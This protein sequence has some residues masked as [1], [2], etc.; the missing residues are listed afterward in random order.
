MTWCFIQKLLS[1]FCA[2]LASS[3][4][5]AAS[6]AGK[7]EQAERYYQQALVSL[8]QGNKVQAVAQLKAALTF[9][10]KLAK[11]H[12]QLAV[13]YMD[14][15]TV[16]GRAR[17][18][19]EIEQALKLEPRNL[20]FR[21]N[22][23]LLNLKKGF[24]GIAAKN[25]ER[26]LELDP[27]NYLACFHLAQIREAEL[28]RYKDMISVD[29]SS[30]VIITM[31]SFA[32]RSKEQAIYYYQ[33]AIAIHPRYAEAYYRLALLFYEYGEYDRMVQL[34]ES[35]VKVIPD[36]KN[37]LLFLGFAYQTVR[38]YSRAASAYQAAEKL[39][40]SAE[41]ELLYSAETILAPTEQRN[42]AKLSVEEQAR[43]QRS[44]WTSHD[45][46]FLTEC[47][48]RQMEHFRRIAYA[49]LRFSDPNQQREGWQTDQGKVLIR[50][51]F[52]ISKYRTRPFIGSSFDIGRNPLHPS[53]EV[54][55]YPGFEFVFEDRFLSDH[56]AFAWGH[57][58]EDDYKIKFEQ[59]IAKTPELHELVPDS[60]RLEVQ[61][62][63][64][65]FQGKDEKTELELCYALPIRQLRPSGDRFKLQQG[66]FLFDENWNSII[67]HQKP[68]FFM[69]DE[70]SMI[71]GKLWYGSHEAL[72]IA[73]G[74]YHLAFEF[75]D[76]R[77]GRR[78]QIRQQITVSNFSPQKFQLSEILF[79]KDITLP[80]PSSAPRRSD[81]RI[82]PNPMRIYRPGE[83]LVI[84]FELYH[85]HQDLAGETRFRI[86]YQ[87]EVADDR[88]KVANRILS[89]LGFK[90]S[91]SHVTSSYEY[92]GKDPEERQHLAISIPKNL[93]GKLKLTLI[94]MDLLTGQ[95]L[96]RDGLF[97]IT[98]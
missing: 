63:V 44:F 58:S 88:T 92:T 15:G 94:A 89:A 72:T 39:M 17:A 1:P 84:Y 65:A 56:F 97:W 71:H 36:D 52:P 21:I 27:K 33:R 59:L 6:D 81:F 9:N 45:P 93:K 13:I 47:N 18:T 43:F 7:L 20:E 41:Q 23:A 8:N 37:C 82:I 80:F 46:F 90:K 48:E 76:E 86:D 68:L 91:M 66:I 25:F 54:W 77:S 29:E 50:Y 51:G 14:E 70:I 28:L 73:P 26:I 98:E 69:A 24:S 55:A 49:N 16:D 30:D 32:E 78:S 2:I 75:E 5:I 11:A 31:K 79:A 10:S 53:K 4:L 96:Q 87:I 64:V 38:D 67:H 19:L 62:D 85:L 74:R 57:G 61:L 34:L 22:E 95:S 42:F 40:T 83:P 60:E 35:A 3:L 12:N